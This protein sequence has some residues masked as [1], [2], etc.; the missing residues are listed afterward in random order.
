MYAMPFKGG[1]QYKKVMNKNEKDPTAMCF[2][3]NNQWWKGLV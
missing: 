3:Y 2:E 1:D